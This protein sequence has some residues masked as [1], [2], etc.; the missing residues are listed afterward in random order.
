M[1]WSGRAPA[2]PASDAGQG[3]HQ[4]EHAHAQV[5]KRPDRRNRHRLIDRLLAFK[6]LQIS[7][8][9]K[10]SDDRIGMG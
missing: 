2:P 4:Q 9:Q 1:G 7:H 3:L 10:Q 8:A 6:D 5:S